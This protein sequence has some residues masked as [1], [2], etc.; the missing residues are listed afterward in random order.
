VVERL[1]A[2]EKVEGSTPFARSILMKNI[3]NSK[4]KEI[5]KL[6]F[7][8]QKE[9]QFYEAIVHY[10]SVIKIDPSIVF[11]YYNLGLIYEKLNNP[12]L[13]KKNYKSAIEIEPLFIYSYNNMGIIY[14]KA[15]QKEK[16]IKYF[17]KVVD[18]DPK[19]IN[20]YNNIGLVYS[21]LGIYDKAI[22]YYLKTLSID[23]DN[24]I[25]LKS[26]I[27]LMNYYTS[28]IN[29]PLI[30]ANNDLRLLQKNFAPSDLLKIENISYIFKNSFKIL[31]KLS[32]NIDHLDFFETQSYRRNPVDLNCEYH[33]KVFNHS[34]IIP[35]FCFS[36]FK[37][38]IDLKNV[39]DLIRLFFIFDNLNLSK[40]NQ[41]KCMVEFRNNV[42][43]LYKGMIYCSSFEEAKKILEQILP[44][45]KKSFKFKADIKRGCSEFYNLFP[46]YKIT[47]S[48][49]KGFLNYDKKW[50][51]IEKNLD[52]KQNFNT[53]KLNYSI[54]GLSI[55]DILIISHWL[56][57][58]K[59]IG[60][61]TYKEI[62]LDFFDSKFIEHQLLNQV[63]FRTKQFNI[64]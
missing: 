64:N 29:H 20:G 60:D 36:C 62:D 57:Y 34:K 48:A 16:A 27:F 59:I 11:A 38:Q 39:I 49:N 19:N 52:I 35:K 33:H 41:R 18:I 2:N 58:A 31:R 9:K 47:D 61:L 17:E 32:I 30:I 42:S 22:D 12:E 28:K 50:E 15:G 24:I 37:V 25:A 55:S 14:Q 3:A 54:P 13:A 1:V 53:I 45:L 6:A 51:E 46:N 43:G 40:N 21:S 26:I 23:K 8:K 44:L 63:E 56:N 7:Q 5:L 10:E 4:V